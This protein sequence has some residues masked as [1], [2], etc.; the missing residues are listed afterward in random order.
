MET[1]SFNIE[2]QQAKTR[3]DVFST[4]HCPELS[5]SYVQKLIEEGLVTIN[6]QPTK[7][8]YKLRVGD[9]VTIEIPPAEELMVNPED[10]PL[11]IYF[12]DKDVIVVN[13]PRGMVVHP[14]EGNTSGTLV[15]AL[16]HHCKDLSGING[17]LRPGIVHRLDK[18][19][20]GLIM[21]AKNDQA[22]QS[23]AHQLKER[24]V[25]RC[26]RALVHHNIKEVQ[27]TINAPIGRDPKDRQKMT[28]TE[29]N[30]K[31]AVTHFRVLE[32]FGN[33]TLIECQLET[34]RTHQ[35]RV[36]MTY[37]GYPLVGDP[38]YGP[39]KSHFDLD[40][41]LLHAMVLGFQHPSSGSYLEFSAPIPE[42]FQRV[43]NQLKL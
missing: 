21:V 8:N 37:I 28:V 23:L 24:T 35:I 41:Q 18:D 15:N 22:H 7:A 10:I 14:A 13:K 38:K 11:D 3:V 17:V 30:S 6:G 27:G 5:R 20:S 32:R 36:H 12:E 39:K 43:L 1:Y 33:Y 4:I 31:P 19:T 34:G 9:E 26:Y 2:Q 16:L 42:V 40:G 29:R 25:T